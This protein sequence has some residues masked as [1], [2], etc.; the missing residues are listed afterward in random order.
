MAEVEEITGGEALARMLAAHEV[1]PMFGMGGFQLLPFYDAARR[2]GIA[3]HLINDERCGVFAAD[4]YAKVS[5]RVGVCDATLGPGATN[6]VTGLVEALNSGTPLVALV[7]DSHRDHSWKNMT[8]ESRQVEIL[9]PAAKEVIRVETPGRIPELMRRAFAVATSG[10]PGPVVVDVPEDVAHALHAYPAT[11]FRADP[12]A[13]RAPALRCRPDA[14]S[15]AA[16][17]DLLAAARRPLV[18]AGGG[19]HLSGAAEALQAFAQAHGIPVAHTMTGKGAIA[20]THPLSAGLFGRYDRIANGLIAESDCLLVVGC[21]LGEI[22]TKRYTV[23]PKN[24]P[25][26][27]L[28]IVAEEFDRVA[29]P[30]VALWA[31]AREGI[32]DLDRALAARAPGGGAARAEYGAD[33]ARRM[34]AWREEVRPRLESDET[35]VNMARMLHELN[36]ALPPDAVLVADGGFAAHWGGLLYDTKRPGRGFVPDRGFASIGYGLPGAM[37]AKLGAPGSPVVGITGD[38]GFNMVLGEL[39]T[40]RRLGLGFAVIVVNNAA[41][42]YVKA[43]QHLMYGQ[44]GYQSSDLI[45]MDYAKVARALGCNGIRVERPGELRA[46]I[47][48]GIEPRDVPTVIDVVVTRDPARMLPGVDNRTV[49]VRRGDRVA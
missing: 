5:G 32:V 27:H 6:L 2:L 3:H 26:I 29:V 15:L 39:E 24:T 17:V 34:A 13:L 22:A 4:A 41:S 8:Q 7:G 48:A 10:R 47:E 35:P 36:R 12:R 31:D 44:G 9:R 28:D 23:L 19:V 21:K 16:A 30:T 25:I 14:A 43:L 38:G 45:E 33:V 11:E 40:A 46:A 18:L 37:G 42:G 49:Q 20:C 1:G